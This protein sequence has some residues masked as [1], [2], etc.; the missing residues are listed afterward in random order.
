MDVFTK[1]LE[2]ARTEASQD[3]PEGE[4][5]LMQTLDTLAAYYV[6]QVNC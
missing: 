1:V 5:D 4:K 6:Q 3:Y 2:A